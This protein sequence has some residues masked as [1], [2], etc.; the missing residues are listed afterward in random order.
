[1]RLQLTAGARILVVDDDP[2]AVRLFGRVLGAG[3][4]AN[5][6]GVSDS[7]QALRTFHETL[8]GLVVLDLH[9]PHLPVWRCSDS[10]AR[11][12][13]RTPTSPLS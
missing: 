12:S 10:C 13:P 2:D 3:G 5:W 4:F 1:M 6:H 8:P 11:R 7:R 9:M